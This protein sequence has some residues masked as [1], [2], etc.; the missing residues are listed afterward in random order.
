MSKYCIY[1]GK[2]LDDK[3]NFCSNCGKQTSVE[4]HT[5]SISEH[6]QPNSSM[7]KAKKTIIIGSVI[8]VILFIIGIAV[9]IEHFDY[10]QDASI[11]GGP[12]W[13]YEA[14]SLAE[15]AEENGNKA[16]FGVFLMFSAVITEIVTL[17]LFCS[18]KNAENLKQV[19]EEIKEKQIKE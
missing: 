2:E 3:A 1:C 16:L 4:A 17:A 6:R 11:F 10:I 15:W 18:A 13:K 5:T 19:F 14:P 12:S 7:T 9:G 8:A